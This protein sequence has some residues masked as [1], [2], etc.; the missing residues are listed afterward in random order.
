M[1]ELATPLP[2]D[3][4]ALERK[5]RLLGL[6]VSNLRREREEQQREPAGPGEQLMLEF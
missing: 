1:I 4:E 5:V 3:T 6:G 2:A